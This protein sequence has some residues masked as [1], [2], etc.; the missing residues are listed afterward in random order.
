MVQG[1][2]GAHKKLE[3]I[4][5]KNQMK[6]LL[7]HILALSLILAVLMSIHTEARATLISSYQFNGTGNWSI[8]G[9]GSNNSPVGTLDAFVPVGATVEKAF[10]YSSTWNFT[11][12]I[13]PSVNFNGTTVQWRRLGK[14]RDPVSEPGE[15]SEF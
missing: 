13:V 7:Q 8:D 4:H 9:V 6:R 10:L 5:M 12:P 3:G 15:F 11:S 14:F 2:G 1:P